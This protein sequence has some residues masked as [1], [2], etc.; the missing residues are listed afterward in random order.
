MKVM[1]IREPETICPYTM[2]PPLVKVGEIY[3]PVATEENI[4]GVMCY[5][6]AEHKHFL[7]A[8]CLFAPLS[9]IDETQLVNK[10]EEVLS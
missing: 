8:T 3:N 10:K 7:Y 2:V 5:E 1:C 9:N 6:L 4:S